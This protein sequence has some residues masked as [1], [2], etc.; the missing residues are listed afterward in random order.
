MDNEGV[1]VYELR[2]RGVIDQ[3]DPLL[4]EGIL[5]AD[6]YFNW[7]AVH[8]KLSDV[9]RAWGTFE[10]I[11]SEDVVLINGTVRAEVRGF[12][13]NEPLVEVI[14]F[15]HGYVNLWGTTEDIGFNIP[16]TVRGYYR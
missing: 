6:I 9:A 1:W 13:T 4:A 16:I 14:Y 15:G 11:S 3:S 10:I 7:L 5:G 12:S 8:N 2:Q